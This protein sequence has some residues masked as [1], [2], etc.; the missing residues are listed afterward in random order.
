[1][2]N[3]IDT[4]SILSNNP[5]QAD[6]YILDSVS[7]P[8]Y[9]CVVGKFVSANGFNTSNIALINSTT[10]LIDSTSSLAIALSSITSNSIKKVIY[11]TSNGHPCLIFLETSTGTSS[12]KCYAFFLE[13]L[14]H[15]ILLSSTYKGLSCPPDVTEN[16]NSYFDMKVCQSQ[17]VLIVCGSFYIHGSNGCLAINLDTIFDNFGI[18]NASVCASFGT[19]AIWNGKLYFQCSINMPW[20]YSGLAI[21]DANSKLYIYSHV[22]SSIEIYQIAPTSLTYL[23]NF[24][25]LN[26]GLPTYINLNPTHNSWMLGQ[27]ME[28]SNNKLF[29]CVGYTQPYSPIGQEAA[30]L[31]YDTLSSTWIAN[32][33]VIFRNEYGVASIYG[34]KVLD[35]KLYVFGQFTNSYYSSQMVGFSN[36]FY[37]NKRSGCIVF[38]IST[39]AFVILGEDLELSSGIV[40]IGGPSGLGLSPYSGVVTNILI[41]GDTVH[42]FRL[43]IALGYTNSI[44]ITGP[45]PMK[46]VLFKNGI[47]YDKNP[48]EI[49]SDGYYPNTLDANLLY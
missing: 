49:T 37:T 45:I 16:F 20:S 39:S 38:D 18:S 5:L 24:S 47:Q 27:L 22:T 3:S 6:G 43:R 19:G 9:V 11:E 42:L 46:K 44:I 4:N 28:F 40:L 34:M 2:I 10:G 25:I 30:I 14:Q 8:G 48:I 33:P 35:N 1:M 31:A 21:D 26:D 13:I 17:R 36:S 7:F 29:I 32:Y 12:N 23:S 15:Y 41:D